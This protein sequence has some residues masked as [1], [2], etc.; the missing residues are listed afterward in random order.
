MAARRKFTEEQKL[1]ILD[2][3]KATGVI[4]ALRTHS[5]SYS[6]YARWKYKFMKPDGHAMPSPNRTKA[7]LKQLTEE[8]IRLKKIIASQALELERKDEELRRSIS[9]F[10]KR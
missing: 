5:L 4:A 7:E 1:Q 9:L 10:G 3:A 6:V 8:N 2:E